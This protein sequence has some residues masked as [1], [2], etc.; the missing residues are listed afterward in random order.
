MSTDSGPK[1]AL[2]EQFARVGKA[3]SSP[4][5]L[6][7]LD[8]LAQGERTVESLAQATSLK[9]TTASAHLQSLRNGG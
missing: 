5:R 6:E 4:K 9:L 8:V 7:L 2:F 3:L 1:N